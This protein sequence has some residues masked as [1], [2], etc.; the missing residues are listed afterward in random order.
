MQYFIGTYSNG[1]CGCDE[2]EY[3]IADSIE[4][5]EKFMAANLVDYGWDYYFYCEEYD[6]EDEDFEETY[7]DNITFDVRKATA[8]E[9]EDIDTWTD[10]R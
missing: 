6:E 10:I 2:E 3:I 4:Q 5:A 8:E 1:Y 9:I 7:W